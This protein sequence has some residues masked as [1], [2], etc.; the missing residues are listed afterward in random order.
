MSRSF[1]SRYNLWFHVI[2]S[3]LNR[4]PVILP[5]N[6]KR[7]FQLVRECFHNQGFRVEAINGVKDHIHLLVQSSADILLADEIEKSLQ[8]SELLINAELYPAGS[9]GWH[10]EYA[11]FSVSQSQAVRVR[12]YISQQKTIH[13]QKTFLTEWK[14]FLEVHGI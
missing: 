13:V 7:I 11:I 12:D 1:K 3:T 9:F 4:L 14:E 2:A 5:E 8:E 6:E 10:S